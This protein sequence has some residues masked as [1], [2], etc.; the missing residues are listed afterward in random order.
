MVQWEYAEL[1][2]FSEEDG[3]FLNGNKLYE[4]EKY[5]IYSLSE[6]LNHVGL[7]GW[8]LIMKDKDKYGN[9]LYRMKRIKKLI[10]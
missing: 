3:Y 8:E 2:C 5:L 6:A 7:D 4:D 10:L 9:K 1:Y